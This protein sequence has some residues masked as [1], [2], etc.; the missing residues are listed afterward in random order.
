MATQE[1]AAR[2]QGGGAST[3]YETGDGPLRMANY[4]L[5]CVA[6]VTAFVAS[7]VM[8]V[9]KESKA[10]LTTSNTGVYYEFKATGF[11][12]FDYF[13]A[14]NAIACFYSAASLAMHIVTRGGSKNLGFALTMVDL[15][16]VAF[17]FSG[18]GSASAMGVLLRRGSGDIYP[19]IC[20]VYGKFC[21]HVS[22]AIVMSM[23]TSLS[24]LVL[25]VLSY[26]NLYK[27]SL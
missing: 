27:S 8:G 1:Y 11:S 21:G 19:R 7:I 2:T 6:L 20:N 13:I 14:V 5:R 16:M 4:V 26:L 10:I 23:F 18:E 15:V 25:V 12:Q 24:Y 22:A 9:A 3:F 17:L